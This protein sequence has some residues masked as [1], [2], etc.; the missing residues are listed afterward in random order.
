[1]T[2]RPV[3]AGMLLPATS[4]AHAANVLVINNGASHERRRQP[5]HRASRGRPRAGPDPKG[6]L[7][8]NIDVPER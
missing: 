4:G 7:V 6:S 1:M 3:L 5:R 8:E 2:T